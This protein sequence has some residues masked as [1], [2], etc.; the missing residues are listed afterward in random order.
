MI[1]KTTTA[2]AMAYDQYNN[3]VTDALF[4][5]M[6]TPALGEINTRTG[7]FTTGTRIG[8]LSLIASSNE[9]RATATIR[10]IP[11]VLDHFDFDNIPHQIAGKEFPIRIIAHD[12][13][14]NFIDTFCDS[15]D[16]SDT[17]GSIMPKQTGS[18]INGLW[19]GT[20]TINDLCLGVNITAN[21]Q[22]LV[23]GTSNRFS[24]LV[25]DDIG[26][27][28]LGS[29]TINFNAGATG[30]TDYYPLITKDVSSIHTEM[31]SIELYQYPWVKQMM[32]IGV[33][34]VD[35]DSNPLLE[36]FDVPA[37]ISV[38]YSGS[39]LE[40]KNGIQLYQLDG[41]KW[42]Y[43]PMQPQF[44][45]I[46]YRVWFTVPKPGTYTLT[47]H[48]SQPSLDLLSVYPVPFRQ[49]SGD[50]HIIFQGLTKDSVIRIYDIA[51]DLIREQEHVSI[52]W[53]WAVI[54][55]GIPSGMYFYVVIDDKNRTR[56][57]RLVIIR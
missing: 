17:T 56:V 1:D 11:C 39:V 4:S 42:R 48:V 47:Y 2:S 34:L 35:G 28:M 27:S 36:G 23:R 7:I 14:H 32:N 16:L 43:V 10:I 57:G 37:T 55:E 31:A 18:F 44:D 40:A 29:I 12:R 50:T 13:Y 30:G 45:L 5:W 19:N 8:T 20:V 38:S 51:G 41:D 15:I 3:R 26:T 22:G 49:V 21:Y 24:A 9:K 33:S 52:E 53:R 25:D 6:I 46:N 54:D